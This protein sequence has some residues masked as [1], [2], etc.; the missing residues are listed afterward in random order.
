MAVQ[1][2]RVVPAVPGARSSQVAGAHGDTSLVA[3]LR[4]AI[5]LG[6]GVVTWVLSRRPVRP[7]GD[8][9]RRPLPGDELVP[10]AKVRWTHGITIRARPNEIWPWLI[11]M[12]CRRAGWYSYDG[13]DNGG[14]PSADRIVLELQRVE[15][16][17]IFPW[18]PAAD[19]GF[20][21]RA[22]EPERALILGGDGVAVSWAL[23]LEPIDETRTR[24][25][26]RGSGN[27]ERFAVGLLLRLV[28]RPIH[29]GMQRRQLLNLKRRAEEGAASRA[30]P[31][32]PIPPSRH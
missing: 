9:A 3:R 15:V 23:I 12:G 7:L 21:V 20:V 22:V 32:A 17:D 13:L 18:T 1:S 27:Y 26:T 16:G 29:F 28:W 11:Q 24:L 19:D 14:V 5:R 2:E 4:D 31:A 10:S 25:V 6:A 30:E 8:E